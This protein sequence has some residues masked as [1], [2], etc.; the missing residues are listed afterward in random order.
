M[1][2][3][4]LD[5]ILNKREVVPTVSARDLLDRPD[6]V[7]SDY[8]RH[9]RTYVPISRA[10]GDEQTSVERFE[11]KVIRHIVDARAPR[12]YL[13]GEYGYGK[14]STAL[15]LWQRAEEA[16]LLAV[17]PFQMTELS[18]LIDALHGWARYRLAAKAG[19]LLPDL[20]TLYKNATAR[21]VEA[22]AAKSGGDLA[23]FHDL[24]R[25]GQLSLRLREADFL[26]YFEGVTALAE[27]AGF[28]GV[29]LLPDEIQ[30]YFE[31]KVKAEREDPIAPFFNLVQALATR[32]KRLRLGLIMVIPHKEIA[33]I[34][35]N[36]GRDDLLQ[37]MAETSLDL[38]AVY[39]RQFAARLWGRLAE[40]F[41]FR[42][43]AADI[44]RPETLAALGE[45]S[46]RED[47]SNGP[48]T[49]INAYRRMVER[50]QHGA[51][52]YTPVDLVDDL[53]A[54]H[55]PFSGSNQIQ[56][57][58]RRALQ[59]TLVKGQRERERAIKLAAAFPD[60]GAPRDLQK[61]YGLNVAFDALMQDALGRL[62][63]HVGPIER[64]GVTLVGLEPGRK[65][66]EW[67]PAVISDLRRVYSPGLAVTKERTLA[68]LTT[69]LRERVFRSWQLV[70]ES[71]RGLTVDRRLV[72]EGA[73][74]ATQA[75]FPRRRVRVTILWEDEQRLEEDIEED[76]ELVLR[77]RRHAEAEDRQR[78]VEPPTL[79]V[80]AHRALLPLNLV[81]ARP[82]G[83]A[84][85]LLSKLQSVWS[86]YELTPLVLMNI[87]A[88]LDEK[89]AAGVIP[90]QDDQFIQAD[91]QPSLLDEIV[92]DLLNEE[93]GEPLNRAGAPLIEEVVSRLL[94]T[95]YGDYRTLMPLT[96]W[97]ESLKKYDAALDRLESDYH[98][99]GEA[100]VEGTKT[101]I[102]TTF[103]M[104]N[105]GLDS[106]MK[107]FG[108]LIALARDW[109][110]QRAE[111]EGAK[112][113]VRFSLHPEER[114]ILEQL[115]ASPQTQEVTFHGRPTA[116]RVLNLGQ[117]RAASLRRGYL[118]DEFTKL[119]DLLQRRGLA[120]VVQNNRWL[121]ELPSAMPDV[122]GLSGQLTALAADLDT[123]SN[124]FGDNG[125]L[126]DWRKDVAGYRNKLDQEIQSGR[127]DVDTLVK[128]GKAAAARQK[129][130]QHFAQEQRDRLR[131]KVRLIAGHTGLWRPEMTRA[132]A[133]PIAGEVEYVD[134]VE[135]LRAALSRQAES[136]RAALE[137]DRQQMEQSRAT[138]ERDDLPLNLLCGTA[139]EI[140]RHEKAAAATRQKATD[141]ATQFDQMVRWRRMVAHGGELQARLGELGPAAVE[142]E[143]T[144]N[145]LAR[146][147]RAAI[148]SRPNKLDA[149]PDY[150]IFEARL[151]SLDGELQRL[152]ANARA[153]FTT[154]Q[155]R[156]RDAL[157]VLKGSTTGHAGERPFEFNFS[158]PA[159]S[160]RLLETWLREQLWGAVDD[161]Q[162]AA[163][164]QRQD[165]LQI[166]QTPFL[167]ELPHDERQHVAHEASAALAAL[168]TVVADVESAREGLGGQLDDEAVVATRVDEL[169]RLQQALDASRAQIRRLGQWLDRVA[170]T[171]QEQ[172]AYDRLGQGEAVAEDLVG[173][174]AAMGLDDDTFWR[175]ARGLFEKRRIRLH[176]GRVGP[177]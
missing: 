74:A 153:A 72:F 149:L 84:P 53:L 44:V 70:E 121:R 56:A 111:R 120:E 144:F 132:L 21:S 139:D 119:L 15:Y 141:L 12:G 52:A 129:D 146:D 158:N 68:V 161:I 171:P 160:Y 13:T 35:D 90:R 177:S 107:S 81:Y 147:I 131:E 66:T 47:L 157:R 38:T 31:P 10:A 136:T 63:I 25:Q 114:R 36:R 28:A 3:E 73:F 97:R 2:L 126:R 30:Q 98:R 34:R 167:A 105:P 32:D 40:E 91:F 22:H 57:V 159:E 69:L 165:V 130:A 115:R 174:R 82:G 104:S 80:A 76:V 112:G 89:R 37:R 11:Q 164:Q 110:S 71:P 113:A 92:R 87:F 170:L 18:Q 59:D 16:R 173:W 168:A 102:A 124:G 4:G 64:E 9:V 75:R 50:Y 17:P 60:D 14:T 67:L 46:A 5:T 1:P 100:E 127:P 134:Q 96:S 19:E 7:E 135:A 143:P 83:I 41:G 61:A 86:P 51:A 39:D 148:S 65:T 85:Q 128:L 29:L 163:D 118:S 162:R 169:A 133:E 8:R 77:L 101:E 49:V 175:V 6:Q 78:I 54:G 55:I 88:L 27:R 145:T 176:V 125:R 33:L 108:D 23:Y 58:A 109:P 123:L 166:Q 79:D 155:E 151:V 117:T 24:V 150:A 94:V 116:V 45:I 99:R 122:E 20:D 172:A 62:V 152:R 142:L 137:K 140:A 138:L 106:F 156:Y 93:V 103:T 154:R 48:R 95:R 43:V 26:A 42:E